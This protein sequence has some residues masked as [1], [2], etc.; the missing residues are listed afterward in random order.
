MPEH[1]GFARKSQYAP[2]WPGKGNEGSKAAAI[3]PSADL[4]RAAAGFIF[5][6]C[7]YPG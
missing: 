4:F 3:F 7:F 2:G 6:K 5:S 1:S